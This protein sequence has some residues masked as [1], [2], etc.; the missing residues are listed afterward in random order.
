MPP[1]S[2]IPD[3]FHRQNYAYASAPRTPDR[4]PLGVTDDQRH[5][6]EQ[7]R[8][9][10]KQSESK[11]TRPSPSASTNVYPKNLPAQ[12]PQIHHPSYN[13][14]PSPISS[15]PPA[16]PVSSFPQPTQTPTPPQIQPPPQSPQTLPSPS[17]QSQQPQQPMTSINVRPPPQSTPSFQTPTKEPA[18]PSPFASPSTSLESQRV[19]ALLDLN[20][21]LIQEVVLLQE[22]QKENKSAGT[23]TSNPQQNPQQASPSS[24]TDSS[25]TVTPQTKPDTK[26]EGE[27]TTNTTTNP[28]T[29]EDASSSKPAQ[30]QPPQQNK[31]PSSKE[32]I[33][34]MRRLQANLA[35]LASVAD[36]HH[37]PGNA[38]AQFPAFME[39]PSL[40][41]TAVG[42][43][44]GAEAGEVDGKG[45]KQSLRELYAKLRELWPEYKGKANAPGIT[46]AGMGTATPTSA[47]TSSTSVAAA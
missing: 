25:T 34:Y 44:D 15:A 19:S 17:S 47:P 38:V 43:K 4:W 9:Q 27:T 30:A 22:S 3:S 37:K 16:G 21:V 1:P 5:L 13:P 33:D 46:A 14:Q 7:Y 24:A 6:Q 36:R 26:Q 42:G 39:A 35:Y 28:P 20:R 10:C 18:N 23:S 29:T 40:G 41:P 31:P 2:S 45:R 8:Q 32:Y 12:T 11:A